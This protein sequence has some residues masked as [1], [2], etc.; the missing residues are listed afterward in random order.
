MQVIAFRSNFMRAA[1]L[2]AAAAL[3]PAMAAE[4]PIYTLAPGFNEVRAGGLKGRVVEIDYESKLLNLKRH[5]TVYLPAAY[6]QQ[7]NRKFPVLYLRHGG[8]EDPRDWQ[9]RGAG[10]TI[11]DNLISDGKAVP[12]I[13]AMPGTYIP[14]SYG[15]PFEDKSIALAAS[16]FFDEIA[17]LVESRFRADPAPKSRAMIGFSVGGGQSYF[18]VM[19]NQNRI[20]NLG[21]I[22][23]GVFG[24][25]NMAANIPNGPPPPPPFDAARD[26]GPATN[27]AKGF[28]ERVKVFF[29]T[30][31]SEDPRVGPTADAV[32]MFRKAGVKVDSSRQQGGHT[33]PVAQQGMAE[34]AQK[35]FRD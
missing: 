21:A 19:H 6:D 32:E 23:A 15:G 20:G 7:P 25:I 30:V 10:A 16:E 28:N 1:L 13:V 2:L 18:I 33:W 34:F 14:F 22:G 17:P 5:M 29:L 3:V 9:T 4:A 26:L 27:D 12:M 24:G 8:G 35:L 11:V 31:G